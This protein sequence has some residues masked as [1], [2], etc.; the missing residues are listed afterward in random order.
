[1][2]DRDWKVI[3]SMTGIHIKR[4]SSDGVGPRGDPL[5]DGQC[6][7]VI[8]ETTQ[9]GKISEKPVVIFGLLILC[10]GL[11]CYHYDLVVS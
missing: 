5:G 8:S 3:L 6:Y 4:L 7:R 10:H 2:L 11:F 1:M 9:D